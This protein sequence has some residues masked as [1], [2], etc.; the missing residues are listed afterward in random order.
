M[1][2]PQWQCCSWQ[3]SFRRAATPV[4]SPSKAGPA[5]RTG[6]SCSPCLANPNARA[7]KRLRTIANSR[8][9]LANPCARAPKRLRTIANSRPCLANPCA[10]APKCLRTIANSRPC[11]ANPNARAQTG[12]LSPRRGA[13]SRP[14]PDHPPAERDPRRMGGHNS[15]SGDTQIR[16]RCCQQKAQGRGQFYVLHEQTA[17]PRLSVLSLGEARS[18]SKRNSPRR[19]RFPTQARHFRRIFSWLPLR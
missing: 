12:G 18:S 8:P 17:A 7:P 6:G 14:A 16:R 4:L 15:Y 11:L 19:I 2:C 9:G 1:Y 13:W 3:Y 10:R 5:I